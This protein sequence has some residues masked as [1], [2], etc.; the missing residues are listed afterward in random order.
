VRC[1]CALWA[2]SGQAQPSDG[3]SMGEVGARSPWRGEAAAPVDSGEPAARGGGEE[4][5][6]RRGDVVN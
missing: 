3:M 6:G 5:L 1:N 2:K 4:V